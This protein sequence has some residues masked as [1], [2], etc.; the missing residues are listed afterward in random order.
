MISKLFVLAAATAFAASAP[1]L[2][3]PATSVKAART[4]CRQVTSFDP[5]RAA[6]KVV[7]AKQTVVIEWDSNHE[8]N[9][10]GCA[11]FGRRMRFQGLEFDRGW[12]LVLRNTVI[13]TDKVASCKL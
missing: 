6:C 11:G 7:A 13:E 10:V 3:N 12:T 8:D 5:Q 1:A 9:R 4:L 2:A